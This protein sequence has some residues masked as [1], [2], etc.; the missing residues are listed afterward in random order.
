M[1]L[2]FHPGG[3]PRIDGDVMPAVTLF[4]R[5][6]VRKVAG[7]GGNEQA[8]IARLRAPEALPAVMALDIDHFFPG[9]TTYA[10]NPRILA[11]WFGRIARQSLAVLQRGGP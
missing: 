9:T 5:Q 4:C 7:V 2:R 10:W 8:I 6:G 1:R 11:A 3:E